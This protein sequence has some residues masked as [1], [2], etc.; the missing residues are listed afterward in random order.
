MKKGG[1]RR[2]NRNKA[3]DTE[4][5]V[6]L[7]GIGLDIDQDAAFPAPDDDPPQEEEEEIPFSRVSARGKKKSGGGLSGAGSRRSVGGGSKRS[8]QPSGANEGGGSEEPF[9]HILQFSVSREWLE[10]GDIVDEILKDEEVKSKEASA[11]GQ[12]E[13]K[14]GSEEIKEE[15]NEDEDPDDDAARQVDLRKPISE[16]DQDAIEEAKMSEAPRSQM[17]ASVGN[18]VQPL[19]EPMD[20]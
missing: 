14:R 9:D 18:R 12:E 10:G 11:I 5:H 19:V 20:A 13:A 4:D 3:M 1:R 6:N 2:G 16:A 17:Q 7:T 8:K 15:P